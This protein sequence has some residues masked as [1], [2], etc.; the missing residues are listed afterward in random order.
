MAHYLI[1]GVWKDSTGTITHYAFHLYNP[2]SSTFSDAVKT[3]KADAV[4]KLLRGD[5]AQTIIWNYTQASWNNGSAVY[6]AGTGFNQ[7]LKS[8]PDSTVRDN[9]DNIINYVGVF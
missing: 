9:L 4:T 7:Y 6:V 8:N 2:S 3:S 1:S 5:I